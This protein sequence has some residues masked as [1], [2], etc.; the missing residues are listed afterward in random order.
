MS[1]VRPKIFYLFDYIPF[2][3]ISKCGNQKIRIKI[4]LDSKIY[5]M[6]ISPSELFLSSARYEVFRKL[7]TQNMIRFLNVSSIH[8]QF[9]VFSCQFVIRF[10]FLF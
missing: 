7:Q 5:I 2:L 6:F 10:F 3:E 1:H 4:E 9:S 8:M